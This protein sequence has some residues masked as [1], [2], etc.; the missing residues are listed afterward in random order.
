[1]S[2][3]RQLVWLFKDNQSDCLKTIQSDCSKKIY[4]II[5]RHS[6]WL[7]DWPSPYIHNLLFGEEQVY[8]THQDKLIYCKKYMW[9]YYQAKLTVVAQ[10]RWIVCKITESIK[11]VNTFQITQH[12]HVWYVA[13][14]LLVFTGQCR[15]QENI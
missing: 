9:E 6:V 3:Q 8:N 5:L 4:L 14:F 7:F 15:F 10:V 11:Q 12:I 2:I 13:E 1:M